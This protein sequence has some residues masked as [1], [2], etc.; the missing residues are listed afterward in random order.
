METHDK[1]SNEQ[2]T[3]LFVFKE[4][5]IPDLVWWKDLEMI[6]YNFRHTA[7]YLERVLCRLQGRVEMEHNTNPTEKEW[8]Q[9]NCVYGEIAVRFGLTKQPKTICT[10]WINTANRKI[11]AR[12]MFDDLRHKIESR[13]N[14]VDKEL[15]TERAKQW[16]AEIEKESDPTPQQMTD[17]IA[18]QMER[19]FEPIDGGKY[20][21]RPL[22]KNWEDWEDTDLDEYGYSMGYDRMTARECELLVEAYRVW[23]QKYQ[24]PTPTAQP[25][26]D[27]RPRPDERPD[28]SHFNA[29]YTKDQLTTIFERLKDGLYLPADSVLD[30]WLIVCGAETTNK[31]TKPLNWLK[32]AGLLGWLV[33]SMFPNDKA[34]YWAITANCFMVKGKAPNANTMKNAVSRVGGNYKDKPKAFED[35]EC[36]LKV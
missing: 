25:L 33:Y 17:T 9:I 23:A 18:V 2:P 7:L 3:T 10:I 30:D 31:P 29:P 22:Y 12:E 11:L 15:I 26:N 20:P 6:V 5:E 32:E 24:Q 13:C 34:N 1:Q 4:L 35:L 8:Q 16:F 14:D 28:N 27:E 21:H 36:L 19:C